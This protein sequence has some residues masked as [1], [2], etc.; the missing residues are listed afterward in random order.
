MYDKVSNIKNAKNA[1]TMKPTNFKPNSFKTTYPNLHSS[2]LASTPARPSTST[3]RNENSTP[4]LSSDSLSDCSGNNTT[5][6]I[7]KSTSFKNALSLSNKTTN[8]G[9]STQ[10]EYSGVFEKVSLVSTS[11]SGN[12]N[13]KIFPEINK[14]TPNSSNHTYTPKCSDDSECIR[15]GFPSNKQSTIISLNQPR[16]KN[17]STSINIT[18]NAE[19][20]V[21]IVNIGQKTEKLNSTTQNIADYCKSQC[22]PKPITQSTGKI[23][24]TVPKSVFK[25]TAATIVSDRKSTPNETFTNFT[26]NDNNESELSTQSLSFPSQCESDKLISS[27]ANLKLKKSV[28]DDVIKENTH[29]SRTLFLDN[30]DPHEHNSDKHNLPSSM[31]NSYAPQTFHQLDLNK[32]SLFTSNDLNKFR[33]LVTKKYAESSPN[34]PMKTSN[35]NSH[36]GNSTKIT[37]STDME[38]KHQKISSAHM[39]D[40]SNNRSST[41]SS[42]E[43]KAKIN[44]EKSVL[45][46]G[47]DKNSISTNISSESSVSSNKSFKPAVT[48][49]RLQEFDIFQT[50]KGKLNKNHQSTKQQEDKSK[51]ST[52]FHKRL[53]PEKASDSKTMSNK[54]NHLKKVSEITETSDDNDD[55][56]VFQKKAVK[57]SVKKRSAKFKPDRRHSSVING[58]LQKSCKAFD[59]KSNSA[60]VFEPNSETA[61]S[62][63]SKK[64]FQNRNDP[65]E[66]D[67]LTTDSSKIS[68]NTNHERTQK[69]KSSHCTKNSSISTKDLEKLIKIRN[70]VR[71]PKS[72]GINDR[73]ASTE[74][75]SVKKCPEPKN[76]SINSCDIDNH[77]S[78]D[79]VSHTRNEEFLRTTESNDPTVT[80]SIELGTKTSK[81]ERK[82]LSSS[83]KHAVDVIKDRS[84]LRRLHATIRDN[85]ND[86][87]YD[88]WYES[89]NQTESDPFS[90]DSSLSS[91]LCIDQFNSSDTETSL[92]LS[93]DSD[94]SLNTPLNILSKRISK[95]QPSQPKN[96]SNESKNVRPDAKKQSLSDGDSPFKRM[97]TLNKSFEHKVTRRCKR[98]ANGI[99]T[100][101]TKKSF[102]PLKLNELEEF[103][104]NIDPQSCYKSLDKCQLCDHE[105]RSIAN[106][107]NTAHPNSECL[108]SRP[109]PLMAQKIKS[110]QPRF[111]NRK[112]CNSKEICSFQCYFC[113]KHLKNQKSNWIM[114]IA[115]HTGEK[116][117]FCNKCHTNNWRTLKY[118][119]SCS[120]MMY[121][122]RKELGEFIGG[123]L[124][125][126]MCSVCN[127]VKMKK[128]RVENHIE[129]MH[130]AE[131]NAKVFQFALVNCDRN[132]KVMKDNCC[133]DEMPSLRHVSDS[134][135]NVESTIDFDPMNTIFNPKVLLSS[136][137]VEHLLKKSNPVAINPN[138]SGEKHCRVSENIDQVEAETIPIEPNEV[139]SHCSNV[140][141]VTDT[142]PI[143]NVKKEVK[144]ERD[145]KCNY[146]NRLDNIVSRLELRLSQNND[147]IF[148]FIAH[149]QAKNINVVPDSTKS[150]IVNSP[151]SLT[152]DINIERHLTETAT[153]I[154]KSQEIYQDLPIEIIKNLSFQKRST[155][156]GLS[157]NYLCNITRCDFKT[158]R[159]EFM[160]MHIKESHNTLKW[161]GYCTTCASQIKLCKKNPI[162][163][164]FDHL[165]EQHISTPAITI[166]SSDD[167]DDDVV[168]VVKPE[169]PDRKP[170]LSEV[171]PPFIDIISNEIL[172]PSKTKIITTSPLKPWLH[173]TIQKPVEI[174][175]K[176]L[177]PICLEQFYKCMAIDCSY[178]T[179]EKLNF[180]QHIVD[181]ELHVEKELTFSRCSTSNSDTISWLECSYCDLLA[182]TCN[183]LINHL[184]YEHI[185]SNFQ[186]GYCFYRAN[187]ASHVVYHQAAH[188]KSF[189]T[190]II[191]SDKR[192][193]QGKIDFDRFLNYVKD[194]VKKLVCFGK[195]FI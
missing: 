16:E 184:I 195:Y 39:R 53:S 186:C 153:N 189:E 83:S 56:S 30:A 136:T 131:E 166:D 113:D 61:Q 62:P 183:D 79:R 65:N 25:R 157:V 143:G 45:S 88:K 120:E 167:D 165:Y 22:S 125:G 190:S 47:L 121:Q 93:S 173:R 57:L 43:Q 33:D 137:I 89:D 146:S 94:A 139:L 17:P 164:E 147:D 158:Q 91:N 107:Y 149:S 73:I 28:L 185:Q 50:E 181:H 8:S 58:K 124:I 187:F 9:N 118:C 14:L 179:N 82:L 193:L 117:N 69:D 163:D 34:R 85:L 20:T 10:K 7:Q 191:V 38:G 11:D 138:S 23:L 132:A 86:K 68:T 105:S 60:G 13:H 102:G 171:T 72:C 104:K 54:S 77:V 52:E 111:G 112:K 24:E 44:K 51:R 168:F 108:T 116:Y 49:K 21:L 126:Y 119:C 140:L 192:K 48:F 90:P 84:V 19:N 174:Y 155:N 182:D 109:N 46:K 130:Y 98:W 106:H 12:Q 78:K 175:E 3:Y 67:K 110:N 15:G 151:I 144:I 162:T 145:V 64:Q 128:L 180:L 150:D 42:T 122:D 80:M 141:N 63:K 129:R 188:H 101:P 100:K 154:R 32:K 159:S 2:A 133:L 5:Q 127:F 172:A 70:D 161:N 103:V 176:M 95:Y 87:D 123:N 76:M 178:C 55:S 142:N 99:Y 59:A 27:F 35:D 26:D 6:R 37:H 135:V 29:S 97:K 75:N 148:S 81:S 114:H 177:K 66:S 170:K 31:N 4:S 169:T 36:S 1:D 160:Q 96:Q 40:M 74:T 115:N 134:G 156:V 18:A 71:M 194:N 152:Q 41:S 92:S